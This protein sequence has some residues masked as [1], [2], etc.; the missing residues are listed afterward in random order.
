MKLFNKIFKTGG[1][2][3]EESTDEPSIIAEPCGNTGDLNS[4]LF[5]RHEPSYEHIRLNE[6]NDK[7]TDRTF[8]HIC[9]KYWDAE[10]KKIKP[11][12]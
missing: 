3:E 9:K 10:Y 12:N 4:F 1:V 7:I 2:I 5:V 8:C 11:K 6:P